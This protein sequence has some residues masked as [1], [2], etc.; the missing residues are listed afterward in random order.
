MGW[1]GL[2][3][4]GSVQRQDTH[5]HVNKPSVSIKCGSRECLVRGWNPDGLRHSYSFSSRK[6]R[7]VP[8]SVLYSGY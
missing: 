4:C 3:S 5:E 7:T 6:I 2:D 1:C 8:T